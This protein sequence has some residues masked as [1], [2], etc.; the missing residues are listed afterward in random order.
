M[1]R[2]LDEQN[3]ES[4]VQGYRLNDLPGQTRTCATCLHCDLFNRE[5]RRY[6]PKPEEYVNF[7][8]VAVEGPKFPP[9]ELLKWCG[10][11][12]RNPRWKQDAKAYLDIAS[13][14]ESSLKK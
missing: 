13:S 10:E 14:A 2:D 3:L 12:K 11:W 8:G 4:M 5:C 1:A 7:E 6:P 9:T